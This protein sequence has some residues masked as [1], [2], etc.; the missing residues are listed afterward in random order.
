LRGGGYESRYR[1]A[2]PATIP[3]DLPVQK[4][5][6]SCKQEYIGTRASKWCPACGPVQKAKTAAKNQRRTLQRRRAEALA[7]RATA[8]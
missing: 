8:A 2:T 5:C 6:K 7:R 1:I 4:R 3:G